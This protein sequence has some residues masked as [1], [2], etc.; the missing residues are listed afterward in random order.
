MPHAATLAGH[1]SLMTTFMASHL[2]S[3]QPS[4]TT[5]S[6][7]SIQ[8]VRQLLHTLLSVQS[9]RG[10]HRRHFP[11]SASDKDAGDPLNWLSSHQTIC[12]LKP[13]T[14]LRTGTLFRYR[15][16]RP[17]LAHVSRQ[18]CKSLLLGYENKFVDQFFPRTLGALHN[19]T[20][21]GWLPWVFA[22]ATRVSLP[23]GNSV[24][25]VDKYTR[26]SPTRLGFNILL[27]LGFFFGVEDFISARVIEF[28]DA[29]HTLTIPGHEEFF[30]ASS[31]RLHLP[32]LRSHPD[33]LCLQSLAVGTHFSSSL[34][35][36]SANLPAFE[37]Q[38]PTSRTIPV[39]VPRTTTP[40]ARLSSHFHLSCLACLRCCRLPHVIFGS[41]CCS[42]LSS[43]AVIV[44]WCALSYL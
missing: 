14:I 1:S 2:S 34:T 41:V 27:V 17:C 8:N 35:C 11:P 30:L 31:D 37:A 40:Q 4:I 44:L 32:H 18:G 33:R 22:L 7:R 13:L 39:G 9:T 5:A 36:G 19:S 42:V 38:S 21:C 25:V 16:A 3:A 20:P 23:S 43:I 15:P 12:S 26:F 29:F 28:T 10:S 6:S 24:F